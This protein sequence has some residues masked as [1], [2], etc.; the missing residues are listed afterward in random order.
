M[1]GSRFRRGAGAAKEPSRLAQHARIGHP[2]AGNQ[3]PGLVRRRAGG[4]LVSRG[5]RGLRGTRWRQLAVRCCRWSRIS[6]WWRL[7][8]T[9]HHFPIQRATGQLTTSAAV[10]AG[11]V[12]NRSRCTTNVTLAP[13]RR[14]LSHHD[15][16]GSVPACE[17]STGPSA[18]PRP[19]RCSN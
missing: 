3:P 15:L 13:A 7:A 9:G 1:F 8:D 4:R 12:R 18:V 19:V 16:S 2:G 6:T 10:T 17:I 11:R 14:N 5:R